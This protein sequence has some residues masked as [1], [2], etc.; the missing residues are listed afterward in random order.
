M[1][2]AKKTKPFFQARQTRCESRNGQKCFGMDLPKA[3][4]QRMD[5]MDIFLWKTLLRLNSLVNSMDNLDDML[6]IVW[7]IC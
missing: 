2:F 7:I 1:I 4:I 3:W 5:S 6:R